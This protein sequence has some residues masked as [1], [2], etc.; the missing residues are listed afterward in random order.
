L[1]IVEKS[2]QR[3]TDILN[4]LK[5]MQSQFV[6]CT[7]RATNLA[8]DL[9]LSAVNAQIFALQVPD[10]ATLEALAGRMRM[11]SDETL[12]KVTNM[13]LGLSQ[14]IEHIKNLEQTLEDFQA[15]GQMEQQILADE[16]NT[17]QKRLFEVEGK[18][19][20]AIRQITDKQTSFTQ[21]IET[22]LNG[23]KFPDTVEAAR[24]RSIDFFRSLASWGSEG[25]VGMLGEDPSEQ[26][27]LLKAKYTM[28]SERRAH[29]AAFGQDSGPAPSTEE[30]LGN[31]VELF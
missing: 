20:N 3:I 10:G 24:L 13:G 28:E 30:E 19:P 27:E 4:L 23:V 8:I 9:R 6:D 14:V 16:S 2:V 7:S 29:S 22:I 26:M 17:S 1:E 5:P 15:I 12:E 25:G 21:S 31:N 18:I 11:I